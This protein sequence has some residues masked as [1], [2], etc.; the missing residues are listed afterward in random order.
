MTTMKTTRVLSG[1]QWSAFLVEEETTDI[2]VSDYFSQQFMILESGMCFPK[3][4]IRRTSRFANEESRKVHSIEAGEI[5][6]IDDSALACLWLLPMAVWDT[7]VLQRQ[8]FCLI[9]M[10]HQTLEMAMVHFERWKIINI[11]KIYVNLKTPSGIGV[12]FM[13]SG[14]RYPTDLTI[15]G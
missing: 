11:Y 10:W 12:G 4:T 15:A 5:K 7:I 8:L 3:R 6:W 14:S 9:I 13:V 2:W 1:K